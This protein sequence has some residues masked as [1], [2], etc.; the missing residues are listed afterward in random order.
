VGNLWFEENI[1]M[2]QKK[3]MQGSIDIHVVDIAPTPFV[4]ALCRLDDRMLG[5]GEVHTRVTILG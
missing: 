4:A 3:P 5:F 2:R 1:L